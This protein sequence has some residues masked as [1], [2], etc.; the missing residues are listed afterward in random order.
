MTSSVVARHVLWCG[1]GTQIVCYGFADRANP[2]T[3][4][5]GPWLCLFCARETAKT[6]PTDVTQAFTT[7]PIPP[8]SK[9]S[10]S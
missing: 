7:Q 9:W 6:R 8:G 4:T 3:D 10:F 5:A 1:C 2:P